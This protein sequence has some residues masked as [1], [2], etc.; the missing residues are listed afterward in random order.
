MLSYLSR[1]PSD[2]KT[3]VQKIGSFSAFGQKPVTRGIGS[4][5]FFL[6]FNEKALVAPVPFPKIGYWE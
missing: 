4:F 1:L 3:E 2:G 6:L 5:R